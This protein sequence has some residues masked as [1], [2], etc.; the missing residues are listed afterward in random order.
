VSSAPTRLYRAGG[1]VGLTSP[2]LR[3]SP[4]TVGA[5]ACERLGGGTVSHPIF[6][7]PLRVTSARRLR[8]RMESFRLKHCIGS[9]E[10]SRSFKIVFGSSYP[11]LT[12]AIPFV[13]CLGSH[14]PWPG[15]GV[16]Y[17]RRAFMWKVCGLSRHHRR[18][19]GVIYLSPKTDDGLPR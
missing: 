11:K 12:G 2:I 5:I 15:K 19:Y 16:S 3:F 14:F 9:F 7:T 1:C 18:S 4:V 8:T 13:S 17:S 6:W 10:K